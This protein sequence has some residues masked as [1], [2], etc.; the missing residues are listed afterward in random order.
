LKQLTA[1]ASVLFGAVK[2]SGL[3]FQMLNQGAEFVVGE[4]R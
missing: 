2:T 4:P 3:N 1:V